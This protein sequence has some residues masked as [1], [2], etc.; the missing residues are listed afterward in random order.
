[1]IFISARPNIKFRAAGFEIPLI[2]III[3]VLIAAIG[4]FIYWKRQRKRY[5]LGNG[6]EN[7]DDEKELKKIDV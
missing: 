6:E 2:V 3:V 4:L 5:Q 1:M 7:L